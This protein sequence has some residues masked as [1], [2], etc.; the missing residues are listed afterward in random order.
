[1]AISAKVVVFEPWRWGSIVLPANNF[2]HQSPLFK[3][4]VACRC[5]L[6]RD[7]QWS[8]RVA[9]RLKPVTGP[10]PYCMADESRNIP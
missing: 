7:G 8:P 1:M 6:A 9:Y 4:L 5:L 10:A 2:E 3:L